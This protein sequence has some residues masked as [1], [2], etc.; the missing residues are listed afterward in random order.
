MGPLH[1]VGKPEK[2]D[3]PLKG[4]CYDYFGLETH[5]HLLQSLHHEGN[6]YFNYEGFP[7][8]FARGV[9]SWHAE[10]MVRMMQLYTGNTLKLGPEWERMLQEQEWDDA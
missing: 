7:I 10:E 3:H 5:E 8:R 2:T 4:E 9:Y 1:Y 6:L